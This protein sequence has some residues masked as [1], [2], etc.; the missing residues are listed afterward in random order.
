MMRPTFAP[1]AADTSRRDRF[2][3]PRRRASERDEMGSE[4]S[5]S[6]WDS[7]S[8]AASSAYDSV[9]SAASEAV[10]TVSDA[11]SDAYDAVS[12]AASDAYDAVS[13]AA[14]GAYDAVS[15]AA[16]DAYD[17]ASDAASAAYDATASFVSDTADHGFAHAVSDVT[18]IDEKTISSASSAAWDVAGVIPG[19]S[20]AATAASTVIDAGAGI[21]D[22]ATGDDDA[23][24]T[25][26]HEAAYDTLG[27]LPDG[28]GT[29]VGIANAAWDTASTAARATGH[30]MPSSGEVVDQGLRAIEDA[31]VDAGVT[32][33]DLLM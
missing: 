32:P 28:V 25:R 15:D 21:Y 3:E 16:S 7:I 12:D 5:P 18:G 14:S 22:L 8:S 33:E 4:D 9:S 11:V 17:A 29:G 6:V 26:F 10:D 31:A 23:A 20:T 1:T 24:R 2:G 19:I 30:D 13:D 27:F